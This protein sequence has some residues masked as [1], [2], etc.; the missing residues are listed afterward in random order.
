M[1]VTIFEACRKR[2][3]T[4]QIFNTRNF[5]TPGSFVDFHGS[6]R[7]NIRLFLQNCGQIEGY[8]VAGNTVWCN[9][10]VNNS[11]GVVFPLYV[12]E[13]DVKS[14]SQPLCDICRIVGW[15]HHYV[16]KRRYHFII[17][18]D[19]EWNKPLRPKSFELSSHLLHG[20]IHCN[21]FGHLVCINGIESGSKFLSGEQIMDIWDGLCTILQTRKISVHDESEKRSMELRL[22]HGIAYGLSWFGKWGYKFSHGCFGV[23]EQKYDRAIQI[24]ASL[25]L[26]KIIHDFTNRKQGKAIQQIIHCYREASET[27]LATIS[28]LLQ[29]M[30]V[31]KSKALIERK[32][33]MALAAIVSSSS[34]KTSDQHEPAVIGQKNPVDG[35][36]FSYPIITGERDSAQSTMSLQ[37]KAAHQHRTATHERLVED[38]SFGFICEKL[39]S[40]WPARRLEEVAKLVAKTLEE[41][42]E[43]R[44][45]GASMARQD[46]RNA[47]RKYI[48]DTGLIDY[49]LKHIEK[50]MF[51]GQVVR[52]FVNPITRMLEFS[53]AD[54]AKK[55][56]TERKTE[57]DTIDS[58]DQEPGVNVNNDLLYLYRNV[59]QDYP[60]S[61]LLSGA[62]MVVLDSKHFVKEWHLGNEEQQDLRILCRVMPSFEELATQLTRSL[63]PAEQVVIP[64]DASDSELQLVVQCA[65][66]D[67][68]CIME[69]FRV[70]N[71][72][73]AGSRGKREVV[74]RGC[75]LDLRTE[76]RYEGGV[77]NW[78]VD[79]KCGARDDDGE[80][81]V[82]CDACRVWQHTKCNSIE[83]DEAAPSVFLCSLCSSSA[84]TVTES[85]YR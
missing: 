19:D 71:I 28:D 4:A 31:F 36:S 66:R 38:R 3:R 82:S 75:G 73:E 76:L 44:G 27:H 41:H 29:F 72:N 79:C 43:S 55:K 65:L 15:A 58:F 37:K 12:V 70:T 53:L 59:L 62:S 50:I 64:R 63:P 49:S 11:N 74:V 47:V 16:S 24:L 77:D 26:Q 30:L 46:L 85:Q 22:L 83:D 84:G 52:R 6:F 68:Y 32:T 7:D 45:R 35:G 8:L 60:S 40:R 23:T 25:E 21:G 18:E 51:G 2:E 56:K 9:L 69:S 48:G 20:L 81:M 13:E 78:T 1:A 61:D 57:S 14:S 34:A 17:P 54:A 33:A 42:K 80:R 39:D 10:F 5:A 67:T